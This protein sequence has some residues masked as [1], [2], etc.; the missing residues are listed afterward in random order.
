MLFYTINIGDYD[1]RNRYKQKTLVLTEGQGE[2]DRRKSRY[3]KIN[4]HLLPEHELSIYFDA[5][6]KQTKKFDC[7]IDEFIRSDADIGAFA[8]PR[9]NCIYQ[10]GQVMIKLGLA[11]KHKIKRQMQ[12]HRLRGYPH[13]YG[14]TENCFIIRKNN[15]KV[16]EFN[17]LW[18]NEYNKG[19][20]RDQMSMMYAVWKTGIKLHYLAGD[21]RNNDYY[22]NWG[23]HLKNRKPQDEK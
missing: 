8:H 20:E 9:N 10:H 11:N 5:C 1:N 7:L 14:L 13:G 6:L 2:T 15:R 22:T 12:R 17:E 18:W 4:S 21:S 23:K 3:Y 19:S 16:T